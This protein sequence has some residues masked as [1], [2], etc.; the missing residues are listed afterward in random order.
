M[1]KVTA[2]ILALLLI[3]TG[4]SAALA[5]SESSVFPKFVPAESLDVFVGHWDLSGFGDVKSN[6][7][8]TKEQL[9]EMNVYMEMTFDI[10][11]D[12]SIV[13]SKEDGIVNL[14]ATNSLNT[15]GSL[16]MTESGTSISVYLCE[17]GTL[18]FIQN[19]GET[20]YYFFFSK[21]VD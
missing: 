19:S 1:K 21:K 8:Y 5:E 12:K 18:C 13:N 20:P 11:K 16:I 9:V 6:K 10:E 4:L 3:L 15:D 7:Y 17:D 14:T 2:L